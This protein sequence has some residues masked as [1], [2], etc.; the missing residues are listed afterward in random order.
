MP[1]R[2]TAFAC[3]LALCALAAPRIRASDSLYVECDTNSHSRQSAYVPVPAASL[4]ECSITNTCEPRQVAERRLPDGTREWFE[5]R[6]L[7]GRKVKD[8]EY[9]LRYDSLRF[10]EKG[11]YV[12]GRKTGEWA[13]WRANG[14]K[15]YETT[16]KDGM[17][18][19]ISLEY[20]PN[21][22]VMEEWKYAEG[23]I[24]CR[25]GYHKSYHSGGQPK[26]ELRLRNR[27]LDLYVLYDST[28]REMNL[29]TMMQR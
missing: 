1:A 9:Q 8:G 11:E 2:L 13:G 20:W 7:E 19:G 25:D 5:Y 12:F 3:A 4:P 14:R 27:M 16:W 21:G 18:D 29:P 17:M 24:D 26:F 15:R 6:L 10:K 23:K 28:G 22:K